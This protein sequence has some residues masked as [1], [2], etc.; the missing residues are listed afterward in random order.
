[1]KLTDKDIIAVAQ[2]MRN[3]QNH[4]LQV[5]KWN[6]QPHHWGE[7]IAMIAAC[8]VCFW[9][10]YVLPSQGDKEQPVQAECV[11]QR[12]TICIREVVHDTLF[13]PPKVEEQHLIASRVEHTPQVE[14][15]EEMGVCILEED[16]LYFCSGSGASQLAMSPTE[17]EP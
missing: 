6:A 17:S 14:E 9:L 15:K 4:A 11:I 7:R 2:E 12:D 1:M 16:I 3:E 13:L 10:G 5:P 8:V